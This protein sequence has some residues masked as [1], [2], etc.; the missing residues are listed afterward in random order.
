[1]TDLAFLIC[2]ART[3]PTTQSLNRTRD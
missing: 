3:D 2:L 1:L